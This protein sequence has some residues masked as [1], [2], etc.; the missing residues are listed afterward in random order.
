MCVMGVLMH[1]YACRSLKNR[2]RGY[3]VLGRKQELVQGRGDFLDTLLCCGWNLVKD[4]GYTLVVLCGFPQHLLLSLDL[5]SR[6]RF[7]FWLACSLS[8]SLAADPACNQGSEWF[9]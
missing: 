5:S 9:N 8:L 2:T 1:R 3:K 6:H 4:R 7:C